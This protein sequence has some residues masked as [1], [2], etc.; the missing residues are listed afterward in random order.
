MTKLRLI[1]LDD[2]YPSEKNLYGDVF[3]HTRLKEYARNYQCTVCSLQHKESYEYEGIQVLAF[4]NSADL[5]AFLDIEKPDALLVHFANK[6]FI[7]D[8]ILPSHLPTVVWVHGYEV[9]F[10]LSRWFQLPYATFLPHNFIRAWIRSSRSL[11]PFRR[12][13]LHSSIQRNIRF[14]FVSEW[15]KRKAEKDLGIT[16]ANSTIIPNPIDPEEFSYKAKDVS[17]RTKILLIRPFHTRK[18]ANDIAV[19]AI[20]RL[21]RESR[22]F[23]QF[24]IM[25]CGEGRYF[26]ALTNPLKD[27]P[28][29]TLVNRFLTHSEIAQLHRDF[30]IFLCPTRQDAQGVSMCEAMSSGMIPISSHCTAIPEFINDGVNGFTT[31]SSSEIARR[32]LQLYS[33]PNLFETMSHCAAQSIR[34]KAGLKTT[35]DRELKFITDT[36]DIGSHLEKKP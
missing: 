7:E 12:L 27:F 8:I 23:E 13:V 30:G 3:V 21:A 18:Y 2:N 11:D 20:L 1:V 17:Q 16:V 19:N 35:V 31:R 10:F 5:R 14:V 36:I 29:V 22:T 9:L 4:P 6:T 28:N 25:I 24:T 33:G 32:I 15:M 26:S 34:I